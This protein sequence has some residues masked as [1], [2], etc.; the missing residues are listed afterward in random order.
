M[1]PQKARPIIWTLWLISMKF[2]RIYRETKLLWFRDISIE[3]GKLHANGGA[4]FPEL[5]KVWDR[6]EITAENWNEW[7]QLM[8]W[9]QFCGLHKLAKEAFSNNQYSINFDDIN[10]NYVE[11]TFR[12]NLFSTN[13]RYKR[14]MRRAYVNDIKP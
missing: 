2:S 3:D 5:I 6:V 1:R 8:V 9:C 7:H 4:T 10:L 14:Q 12:E 13:A 11:S